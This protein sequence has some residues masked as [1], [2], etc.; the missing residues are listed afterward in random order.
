MSGRELQALARDRGVVTTDC[1]EKADLVERLTASAVSTRDRD[2]SSAAAP[3]A[4]AATAAAAATS[5]S[6]TAAVTGL[7]ML[8]A[9]QL[10]KMIADAGLSSHGLIEKD[11]LVA[12][13]AEAA[14]TLAARDA[15]FP[16]AAR[17]RELDVV[18]FSRQSCPY[19]VH[20]LDGLGRR[21]LLG[22]ARDALVRDVEEDAEAARELDRLGGQGVPFFFSR[23]TGKSAAGWNQREDT[24]DWLVERLA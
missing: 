14:A 5:S 15:K 21:G 18:L 1:F 13:A 2:T 10:R 9:N 3:N 7:K 22:G 11:E 17:Y 19:C 24:L 4:A 6:S 23:R 20:A 16:D 12:R 8:S